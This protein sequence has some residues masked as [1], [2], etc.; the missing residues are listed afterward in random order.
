MSK[1]K[2][3][4]VDDMA[5]EAISDD[6]SLSE[7]DT[8]VEVVHLK[9]P[10]CGAVFVATDELFVEGSEDGISTLARASEKDS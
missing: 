3:E 1:R 5:E 8:G 2:C 6:D 9:C 10:T 7:E 4:W